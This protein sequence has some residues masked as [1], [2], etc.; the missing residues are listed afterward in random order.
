MSTRATPRTLVLGV[1]AL[2]SVLIN[3]RASQ[4][5]DSP[6]LYDHGCFGSWQPALHAE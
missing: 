2:V 4:R 1:I 3:L 6:S 5:I